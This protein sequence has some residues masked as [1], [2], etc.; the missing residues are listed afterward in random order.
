MQDLITALQIFL[1][2]GNPEKPTNCERETLYI[3]GIS[4]DEVL[5]V[6]KFALEKLG[7]FVGSDDDG[8]LCFKSHRFGSA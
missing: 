8:W 3:C 6:D 5:D 1:K 7:F 4:P 2:Y